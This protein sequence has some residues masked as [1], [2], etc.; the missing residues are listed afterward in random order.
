MTAT[1]L[2][3]SGDRLDRAVLTVAVVVVIGAIMSILDTTIVNVALETLSRDLHS[4]LNEVQ[5]VATGYLLALATV[6]PLTGW[7]SERFGSKRVWMT[8]VF[9]F[10]AGSALCGAAWSATSLIVFRVLQGFGGGMV[11]PVGMIILAQAAGPQRIGR[12]MSVVGVPMLLGPVLGPVLGGLIVDNL[13]WRW[14]FYVNLPIGAL[15]LALA[16][17]LL[18]SGRSGDAGRLD[19]RGLAL[20]SPGLALIVYGLSE[21]AGHGGLSNGSTIGSIAA[22]LVLTGAFVR[23]SLRAA[24]PLIDVRLFR[25]REFSAAAAT[26]FM[27]GAALFGALLLL[28]LYYQA[29]RGETPLAAGLLMAPQG[30]GAAAVMP[31]SGRLTDRVGGGRVAIVG[32]LVMAAATIPFT[33]VGA[34]TPYALLAGALFV[35]GIG[36]G[37]SMMPAMAAAYAALETSAVPRATSALNVIQRIGGSIGTALLAVVLQRALTHGLGS[38]HGVIGTARVPQ[39]AAPIV[40]HAFGAAFWWAAGLTIVAIAPAAVLARAHSRARARA[41]RETARVAA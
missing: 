5:W 12:V 31:L 35:R 39:R 26:T 38:A 32:L 7:A 16:S 11:M 23:R 25:R 28:P 14:I 33:A 41:A 10:V 22:G 36:L 3:R 6:I 13:S 17:R 27:V 1:P 21:V 8:S 34:H 24:R 40:A 37:C 9:L 18:P 20:L 30:L 29:A 19:W 4:P 2:P 15:G